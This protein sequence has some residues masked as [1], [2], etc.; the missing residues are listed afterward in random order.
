M[1]TRRDRLPKKVK[2]EY[3]HKQ[4]TD[5]TKRSKCARYI[6]PVILV[7]DNDNYEIVLTSFQSTSSCN[8]MSV[9]SMSE[10]RNFVEAR[11]RGRKE[12]KRV[13]VIEQNT[14]RRLYLKSYSRIDSIDHL[15]KNCNL[16]YRTWKYWHAAMT[17][18]KGLAITVAYDIYLEIT[19]G[20][21]NPSFKVKEPVDF[22]TFRDQLSVQMCQ[23]EPKNQIY[24]G[25]E[26][27]RVVSKMTCTMRQKR[28][29]DA[30]VRTSEGEAN[31]ISFE[32]YCDLMKTRRVCKNLYK[33]ESHLK[34]IKP[35][36]SAA[37]CAVCGVNAFNRCQ[38]CNVALHNNDTKGIG[39][40]RNCA[41]KW[42]SE[43]YLGLCFE[44]R[45]FMCIQTKDWKEAGPTKVKR[46]ERLVQGYAI[47]RNA[48]R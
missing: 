24:K 21:L 39:K 29:S 6:E 37:K 23:Y 26:K 36:K 31:Q 48:Q 30:V 9:N 4:K 32:Q 33:Y 47:R 43:A 46:N 34:H 5:S 13:Y 18:A 2:G 19:E 42:H 28:K 12:H 16:G 11:S 27:M 41:L 22:Y 8:I 40:G 17:H 38:I 20:H 44:D 7:N 25:D 35:H 45:K 3:M 1:T 15:I 14:S 10:N